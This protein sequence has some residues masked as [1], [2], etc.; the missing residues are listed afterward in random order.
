MSISNS[1]SLDLLYPVC[2]HV[3]PGGER[4]GSPTLRS[5]KYCY[6]HGNVMRRVPKVNLMVRLWN[7]D[8]QSDPNYRYDMPYLEDPEALQMAFTQFIHVVS[9]EQMKVDRAR[10]I[11][12]ALHGASLNLR[13]MEKAATERAKTSTGKKP[14]ASVR[15]IAA[16]AQ[17]AERAAKE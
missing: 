6:Y 15:A 13:T 3:K 14:P 5:K 1:E 17:L 2:Q 9:Q 4:C 10:L 7:T 8:P 11:L 12:S 16:V